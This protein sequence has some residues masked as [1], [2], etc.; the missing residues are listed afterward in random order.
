MGGPNAP[1]DLA[2]GGETQ[3]W[4]ATSDDPGALVSG[5]YFYHQK[6]RAPLAAARDEQIQD[7]LIAE[8]GRI[9]G[10]AFPD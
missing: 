1:D 9:S 4:L 3:V 5:Q 2:A 8:C 7:R 6:R 10:V